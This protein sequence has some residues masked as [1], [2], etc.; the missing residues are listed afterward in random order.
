VLESLFIALIGS[1]LGLLIT[2]PILFWFYYH[3]IPLTGDLA[4]SMEEF[5]F[6][7]ILP[8]SLDPELFVNQVLIVLAILTLCILYPLV[9]IVT[10]RLA[11]ALKGSL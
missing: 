4:L 8:F 7:P 6:E 5:G 2:T 1:G 11:Q 10:L 9:R 3:P